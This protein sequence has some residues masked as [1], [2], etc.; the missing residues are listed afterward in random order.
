MDFLHSYENPDA[1]I[2]ILLDQNLRYQTKY[3]RSVLEKI[4]RAIILA[5]KCGLALRG[6]RD[7]GELLCPDDFNDIDVSSGNFRELLQYTAHSGC[8]VTKAH[9]LNNHRKNASYISKTAQNQLIA[10]IGQHILQKICDEVRSAELFSIMADETTDIARTEQF[11]LVIRYVHKSQ[12]KEQ[13]MGFSK[14]EDMTG[15]GVA[16]E[17]KKRLSELQLPIDSLVGQCYDGAIAMAGIRN[18]VQAKIRETH[19]MAVYVHC[20]AHALNLTICNTTKVAEVKNAFGIIGRVSAIFRN[21]AKRGAIFQ[22]AVEATNGNAS[23]RKILPKLCETRWIERH[24]AVLVFVEL[25]DAICAALENL[26]ASGTE[27]SAE[28]QCLLSAISRSSFLISVLT[29]K[30]ALSLWQNLSAWHFKTMKLN[31]AKQLSW[32]RQFWKYSKT[33]SGSGLGR[34]ETVANEA[35]ALNGSLQIDQLPSGKRNRRNQPDESARQYYE[36]NIYNAFMDHLISDM[37][38]R[39]QSHTAIIFKLS[40]LLPKNII[41]NNPLD[42]TVGACF[43]AL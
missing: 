33:G 12:I 19:P 6:R 10:C 3:N 25:F 29:L 9:L 35:E 36:R 21:S 16:E 43:N 23:A 2:D 38:N 37:Q 8:S 40:H 28:A 1:N 27:V 32:F 24:D 11:T 15:L 42:E 14:V 5:G 17:I 7:D 31:F 4:I 41:N 39:F 13:F 26:A 34:F 22:R 30:H 18:G 20:A